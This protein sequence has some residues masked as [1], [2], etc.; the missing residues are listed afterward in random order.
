MERRSISK[1]EKMSSRRADIAST[2]H[3]RVSVQG[4][5]IW[6]TGIHPRAIL[7][8]PNHM[9]TGVYA[10]EHFDQDGVSTHLIKSRKLSERRTKP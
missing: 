7:A 5:P 3:K 8:I 10:H 6:V 9:W 1:S 2:R 4:C